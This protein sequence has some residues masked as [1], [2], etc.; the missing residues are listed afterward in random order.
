VPKPYLNQYYTA[1]G[2]D[3][4]EL[5]STSHSPHAASQQALALETGFRWP[6]WLATAVTHLKDEVDH[7]NWRD[8]VLKLPILEEQLGFPEGM[9]CPGYSAYLRLLIVFAVKSREINY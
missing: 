6:S 5:P 2:P 1:H 4:S 9:V 3:E 8:L 7:P